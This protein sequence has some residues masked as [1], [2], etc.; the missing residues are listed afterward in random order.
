M[1]VFTYD[2]YKEIVQ[3]ASLRPYKR[4]AFL[5]GIPLT[6]L[7]RL[8][9]HNNQAD[10]LDSDAY[11]LNEIS[12]PFQGVLPIERWLRN[13]YYSDPLD[14]DAQH[15][16]R[17]HAD[18]ALGRVAPQPVAG[19]PPAQ[20]AAAAA[21][22]DSVIPERVLWE[23]DLLPIG[24]IVGALRTSASVARMKVTRHENG[25]PK[26]S[27]AT[28]Q[29]VR[30]LGTGWLIGPNH[31]IT[32]HHVINARS[33]G[34]ANASAADFELQALTSKIEF[35]YDDANV[36]GL[37]FECASLLAADPKLDFAV[38]ELKP[39]EPPLQR[40][41]LPVSIR[42]IVLGDGTYLPVNIIQHPGGQTKQ[43]AI[44]NN[45][46]AQVDGADLAYFTDTQGGSSGSP[47]CNDEWQVIALH[48]AAARHKGTFT[49]QG[50][51]TAWVN[52]GTPIALIVEH[53]K[54]L[55]AGENSAWDL[56]AV[57]EV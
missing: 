51:D 18:A 50:R 22:L 45:L 31:V 23:G 26:T 39:K 56:I 33:P 35:D 11:E 57:T 16:Y 9:D 30:Y 21:Q 52:I 13:A 12:R 40:P 24:F 47:V 15:F 55:K 4:D 32:N 25:S 41:P 2:E 17:T 46:A 36:P 43:L 14:T 34:E 29:P 54:G 1:G 5:R 44:R 28:G 6:V 7:A 37:E 3:F 19:S 49:Y 20:A 53:L 38:L 48:K 42:P 27:P 8:P 10:Q